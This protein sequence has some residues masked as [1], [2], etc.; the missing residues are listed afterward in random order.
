MVIRRARYKEPEGGGRGS[1]IEN[2]YR[3][4][5]AS[6]SITSGL[7]FPPPPPPR[8]FTERDFTM[9]RFATTRKY[10]RAFQVYEFYF[11][12][13]VPICCTAQHILHLPPG[14]SLR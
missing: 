7:H 9:M 8:F 3:A 10:G 4:I 13:L 12:S 14:P 1:W 2:S 11:Y 5:V 6:H